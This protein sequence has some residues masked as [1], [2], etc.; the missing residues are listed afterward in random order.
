MW[1]R[2]LV[3]VTCVAVLAAIGFYFWQDYQDREAASA[4]EAAVRSAAL[5]VECKQMLDDVASGKPGDLT[6][7]H[8]VVCIRA[9]KFTTDDIRARGLGEAAA[10]I[11]T[12]IARF[13]L[14]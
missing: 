10:A 1:L 11:D 12:H 7:A 14:E 6:V 3:A 2:G 13:G 8:M 9:D 5:S 4:R